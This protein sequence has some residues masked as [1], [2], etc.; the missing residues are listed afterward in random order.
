[1]PRQRRKSTKL[2]QFARHG[3][4]GTEPEGGEVPA[5]FTQSGQPAVSLFKIR[6]DTPLRR[7]SLIT[8]GFKQKRNPQSLNSGRR[9]KYSENITFAQ[10]EKKVRISTGIAHFHLLEFYAR[11]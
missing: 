5:E 11:P 3:G 6:R 9:Q 1:M 4:C 10:K 7:P 8:V 2:A